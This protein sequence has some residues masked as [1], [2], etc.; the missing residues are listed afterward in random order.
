[1]WK[2]A[3]C[4]SPKQRLALQLRFLHDLQ[5]SEIAAAMHISEGSTKVHLSRAVKSI[6]TPLQLLHRFLHIIVTR[7]GVLHLEG[8]PVAEQVFRQKNRRGD[9]ALFGK[10]EQHPAHGNPAF[11]FACEAERGRIRVVLLPHVLAV[12]HV[13]P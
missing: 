8:V 13:Y 6:R 9:I 1:V 10:L 12:H 2:A 4:V 5:I 11:R 3:K 7:I